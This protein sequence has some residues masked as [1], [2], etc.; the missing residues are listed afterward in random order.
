MNKAKSTHN[1]IVGA[2]LLSFTLALGY[3]SKEKAVK[4]G[5]NKINIAEAAQKTEEKTETGSIA[6]MESTCGKFVIEGTY[7]AWGWRIS[8]AALANGTYLRFNSWEEAI[9]AVGKGIYEGY[10][11]KGLNTSKLI[12]SVYTPPNS[13]KWNRGVRFF[14][15]EMDKIGLDS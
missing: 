11:S 13:V 14:M 6:C 10:A 15:S 5:K 2:F 3:R 12:A 8:G 9:E 1:L 4:T 7:N